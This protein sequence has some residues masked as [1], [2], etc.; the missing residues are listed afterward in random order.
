MSTGHGTMKPVTV[1][2]TPAPTLR[3]LRNILNDALYRG[4]LFLLANTVATSAIGFV[5]WALAAHRYSAPAVGVFSGVTSGVR[6]ARSD[7]GTW[8]ADNHDSPYLPGRRPARTGPYGVMIIAS[9]GTTCVLPLFFS[10]RL[11][12]PLVCILSSTVE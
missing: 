8:P 10:W 6:P 9:V 5:F 4:S 2:I 3:A 12:F 7:R 1:A 11:I